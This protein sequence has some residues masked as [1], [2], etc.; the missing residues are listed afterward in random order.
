MREKSFAICEPD[1]SHCCKSRFFPLTNIELSS[2]V[3]DMLDSMGQCVLL[4]SLLILV[5]LQLNGWINILAAFSALPEPRLS[6][7]LVV[8]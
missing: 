5:E 7:K 4:Q 6:Y 1:V 3:Y 8:I 2:H